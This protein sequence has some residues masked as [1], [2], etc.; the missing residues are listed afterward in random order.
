MY[1]NVIHSITINQLIMSTI[2]FRADDELKMKLEHI[3]KNKGINTS[4][5]IKLYLTTALKKDLNEIT[6]NGMTVAEELELLAM[7][8]EGGDGKIYD[9]VEDLIKDLND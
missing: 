2:A 9:S 4:A 7:G 1:N 5:L 6:E 8:E 3:A